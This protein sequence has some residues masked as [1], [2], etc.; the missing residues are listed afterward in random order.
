MSMLKKMRIMGNMGGV[1]GASSGA[2]QANA[3]DSAN[4]D[5]LT[6]VRTMYQA[7]DNIFE[8]RTVKALFG[9]DAAN[10]FLQIMQNV[11]E[12]AISGLSKIFGAAPG[13]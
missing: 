2:A 11:D 1:A 12:S 3:Q 10:R 8:Y 7:P 4:Q 9:V 13:R 5:A 6:R